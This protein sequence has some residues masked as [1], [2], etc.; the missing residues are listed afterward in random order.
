M[1]IAICHEHIFDGDAVGNDIVGMAKVLI[2]LGIETHL[3]GE[4]VTE[5]ITNVFSVITDFDKIELCQFNILIYHHSTYWKRGAKL[6]KNFSGTIIFRYHNITPANFFKPYSKIHYEHCLRGRKQTLKLA[7]D[8]PSAIWLANS[9]YTRQELIDQIPQLI[10]SKVLPP[11]HKQKFAPKNFCDQVKKPPLFIFV[12]RIAPNKGHKALIWVFNEYLRQYNNEA[13][14]TIIGSEDPNLKEYHNELLDLINKLGISNQIHW[15]KNLSDFE[16]RECYS[17]ADVFMGFSEHEGFCVP[18][19]ESQ[20]M[21][22]PVVSARVTAIEET[23]G[24]DQLLE[25]YP[26]R[27]ADYLF[28]AK[29][30]NEVMINS[31]LSERVVEGGYRNFRQRFNLETLSDSFAGIIANTLMQN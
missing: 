27:K 6:L 28:Y 12:G 16:L 22:I 31:D 19:I 2:E 20:S 9:E 10:D 24:S 14:L 3:L 1:K 13:T 15:K 5:S 7:S 17:K 25:N 26:A 4:N 29:V 18:L 8:F 11:F 21:G 30:L 23:L